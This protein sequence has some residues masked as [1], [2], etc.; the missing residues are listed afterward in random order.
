MTKLVY[1]ICEIE[2]PSFLGGYEARC[3]VFVVYAGVCTLLDVCIPLLHIP[4]RRVENLYIG[5][6]F[7]VFACLF[8]AWLKVRVLSMLGSAVVILHMGTLVFLHMGTL[9]EVHSAGVIFGLWTS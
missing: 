5:V 1:F 4:G 8:L 3:V 2:P 7:V 6:C 9:L